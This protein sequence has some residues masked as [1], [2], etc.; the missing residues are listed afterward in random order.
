MAK[1]TRI[2]AGSLV[3]VV[4]GSLN[5]TAEAQNLALTVRVR[6]DARALDQDLAAAQKHVTHI[7]ADAGID[8]VW[9]ASG[10]RMTIA[11]ISREQA[12]LMHQVKDVMGYAP[13]SGAEGGRLAYVLNH[14]VDEVSAGYNSAK[15][16]VLGVALAHEIGHLLLPSKPHSSKGLMRGK[17]DQSDFRRAR[18]GELLFTPEQVMAIRERLAAFKNPR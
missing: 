2:L 13:A 4:L 15:T 8:I 10:A 17:W 11:L 12:E 1:A 3:I 9:A 5:S 16:V 7:Y 18:L 6:N 14:R